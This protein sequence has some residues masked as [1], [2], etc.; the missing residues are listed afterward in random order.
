MNQNR[1]VAPAMERIYFLVQH[2]RELEATIRYLQML[3]GPPQRWML[4]VPQHGRHSAS[5]FDVP[6]TFALDEGAVRS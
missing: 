1:P 2:T 6:T 3:Q 4:G 5:T